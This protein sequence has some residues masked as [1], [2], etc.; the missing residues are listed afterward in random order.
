M[1]DDLVRRTAAE[2]GG[3][4]V[5]LIVGQRQPGQPGEVS[6]LVTG[7]GGHVTTVPAIDGVRRPS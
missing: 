3:E 6:H 5:E 7:D 4:M 2:L 1:S